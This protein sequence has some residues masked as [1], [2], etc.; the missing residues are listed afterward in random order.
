M[1]KGLWTPC[2]GW[3]QPCRYVQTSLGR[4][5]LKGLQLLSQP[6]LQ[7]CVQVSSPLNIRRLTHDCLNMLDQVVLV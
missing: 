2:L 5:L 7:S 3:H 6:S 1:A 4:I